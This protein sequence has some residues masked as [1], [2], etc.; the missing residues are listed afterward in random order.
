VIVN[1]VMSS[2]DQPSLVGADLT[3]K[4]GG[5][6]LIFCNK[7]NNQIGY[8]LNE[9]RAHWDKGSK[10]TIKVSTLDGSLTA[11]TGIATSSTSVFVGDSASS[12]R[13]ATTC[14]RLTIR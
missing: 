7:A 2:S 3:Y 5:K 8:V 13:P 6:L 11:S 10:I 14:Q 1:G 9:P 4:D 12:P